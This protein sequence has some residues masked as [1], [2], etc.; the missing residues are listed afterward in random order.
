MLM[1]TILVIWLTVLQGG[2]QYKRPYGMCRQ[3][4][5]QNQPLGIRMTLVKCKIWYMNGSLFQNFPK[6]EPKFWKNRLILLKIWPKIGPIGICN[7][8]FFLKNWYLYGSTFKFRQRHILTKTKLEYPPCSAATAENQKMM[9]NS[10][11]AL[12]LKHIDLNFLKVQ[13]TQ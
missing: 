12:H 13:P 6:F 4:G 11:I 9:N 1:I 10:D 8:H 5:S 2:T 3:H 7:G